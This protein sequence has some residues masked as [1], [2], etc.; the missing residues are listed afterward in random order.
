MIRRLALMLALAPAAAVAEPAWPM[1]RDAVWGAGT[2]APAG[3]ALA[4]AAPYRTETDSRTVLGTSV[5]APAGTAVRALTLVIDE[6]PMP[7]SAVIRFAEPQ[8]A[9]AFDATMRLDGPT[10]VHAVAELTDGRSIVA[11]TFVKTSGEGACAA[12]PGTDPAV[13][14]ATL[15]NMDATFVAARVA[16]QASAPERLAALGRRDLAIGVSHPSHSGLQRDQISLLYIPM[17]YISEV[18]V[19]VDGRPFATVEGSISLSENPRLTLSLPA[20]ASEVRVT[21]TD[22]EGAVATTTARLSGS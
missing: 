3:D 13:A 11:E 9:A 19:S 14:L 10:P 22:T 21:M 1:I 12:P 6:N 2:L 8:A 7:V 4:I 20:A 17:R 5:R 15:G 16:P 18:A